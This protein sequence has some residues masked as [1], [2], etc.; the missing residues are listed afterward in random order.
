M[1]QVGTP[2]EI[3]NNPL[4][5]FVADFMGSPSMNLISGEVSHSNGHATIMLERVDGAIRIVQPDFTPDRLAA[6]ISSLAAEPSR[7]TAMA[8]QARS[9]GTLDAAQRLADLVGKVAG[10]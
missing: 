2:F 8:G 4:N 10:V 5:L 7:L 9:V 6:E 3:Y 1:Q